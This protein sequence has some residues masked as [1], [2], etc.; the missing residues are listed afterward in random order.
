MSSAARKIKKQNQ[1]IQEKV[2]LF[3]ALPN[4]CNGCQEDYNKLNKEQA[5]SW[6][7]MVFNESKTVRLYC[8]TC[9]KNVQAWA[10]DFVKETENE[11][12]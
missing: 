11:Q 3:D 5:T 12:L 8:P 10:E 6:S 1:L 7:V 9:Y 4:K 2:M